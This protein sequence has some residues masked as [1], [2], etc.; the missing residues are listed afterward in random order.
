MTVFKQRKGYRRAILVSSISM[1]TLFVIASSDNSLLF[2]YVRQKLG[3]TITKYS[4]FSGIINGVGVFGTVFWVYFIHKK[5]NCAEDNL[6]MVGLGISVNS[7][8]LYA[9][10]TNDWFIYVGME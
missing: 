7:S 6:I 3:W 9:I 2:L 8:I 5:L 4:L 1:L 10:A